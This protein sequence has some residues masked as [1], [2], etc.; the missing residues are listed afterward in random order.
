LGDRVFVGGW[1]IVFFVGGWAIVFFDGMIGRSCL[2]EKLVNILTVQKSYK[3]YFIFQNFY[4]Y[5]VIT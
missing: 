2:R 1:A 4:P 3:N 5:P